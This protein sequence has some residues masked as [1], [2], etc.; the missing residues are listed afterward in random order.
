MTAGDRQPAPGAQVNLAASAPFAPVTEAQV[1]ALI[2]KAYQAGALGGKSNGRDLSD[3]EWV[4]LQ[5]SQ[6][7]TLCK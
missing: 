5:L 1:N 6:E 4:L 3:V 7:G 2:Q